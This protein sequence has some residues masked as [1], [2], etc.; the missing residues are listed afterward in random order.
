MLAAGALTQLEWVDLSAHELM[1][2]GVEFAAAHFPRRD[3]DYL[4]QLKKLCVDRCL[5]VAAYYHDRPFDSSD[6][7]NSAS[8][9]V[10]S[11]SSA[12]AL[13]APLVRFAAAA[14]SGSAGLGWRELV[15]GLK[16]AC[17]DA[18][19][20]N[21]PLAIE[22]RPGTLV[23][24]PVD[25]KRVLKECDSAWLRFALPAGC[26]AGPQADEWNAAL[27][28]AIIVSAPVERLDTFGADEVIDYIAVLTHLWQKHYRGFLSL[29]YR[30]AAP[31][32]SAVRDSVAW[33]RSMI[34]KDTLQSAA[35]EPVA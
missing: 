25:A 29:E 26:L 7:D 8:E 19:V 18:K 6:A 10:E 16:G 11:I 28:D 2:D 35:S 12:A 33:L 32:T 4:A 15:R 13:G 17:I 22:P 21:V 31:E 3:D 14:V 30:G 9:L 23:A 1:L 5:T 27:E 24:T 20:R 34:A